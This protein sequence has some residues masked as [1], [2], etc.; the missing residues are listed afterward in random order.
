[1][2]GLDKPYLFFRLTSDESLLWIL[3]RKAI[4]KSS[5]AL[6]SAE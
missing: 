3:K 5:M 6:S 4:V 1:M 2:N